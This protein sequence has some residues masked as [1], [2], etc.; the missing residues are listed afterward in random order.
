MSRLLGN[1]GL[2]M[3]TLCILP[4]K[5]CWVVFVD[6]MVSLSLWLVYTV[7]VMDSGGNLF[8]AISIATRAALVATRYV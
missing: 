6:A 5:Q 3:K 8:D 7:K 4:G 1:A 2:D